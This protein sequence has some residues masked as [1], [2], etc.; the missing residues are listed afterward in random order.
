MNNMT[1]SEVR[2]ATSVGATSS[3]FWST[4]IDK[5]KA[6]VPGEQPQTVGQASAQ[7]VAV[8]LLAQHRRYAHAAVKK[9]NV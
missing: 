7:G 8:A 1:G 5:L 6:Y 2:V 4:G 3:P 9:A